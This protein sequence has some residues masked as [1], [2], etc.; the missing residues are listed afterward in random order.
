[1]YEAA[2]LQGQ[3]AANAAE[4]NTYAFIMLLMGTRQKDGPTAFFQVKP[5][6]CL[7]AQLNK[8]PSCF[9]C[10]ATN[11]ET[12]LCAVRLFK[13]AIIG[14]CSR[15]AAKLA[16]FMTAHVYIRE[17]FCCVQC[18]EMTGSQSICLADR[19]TLYSLLCSVQHTLRSELASYNLHN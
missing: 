4:F 13:R 9:A 8:A 6:A 5:R 11:C 2:L 15:S 14:S 19:P 18:I 10:R 12:Y 17:S 3:P 1:M 7:L 16:L